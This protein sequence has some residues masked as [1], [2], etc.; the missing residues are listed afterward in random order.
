MS[1]HRP[2]VELTKHFNAEHRRRVAE[3]YVELRSVLLLYES[4]EDKERKCK[5]QVSLART[6]RS[7]PVCTVG[8]M[9]SLPALVRRP[10]KLV[11]WPVN[12]LRSCANSHS[13]ND[14]GWQPSASV[15]I[16]RRATLPT[17]LSWKHNA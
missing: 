17:V 3:K 16:E 1:G 11:T 6:H 15:P 7:S 9:S 10:G 13:K 5:V 12:V 14:F 8:K 4:L 2:F